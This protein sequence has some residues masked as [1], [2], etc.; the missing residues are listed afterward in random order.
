MKIREALIIAVK[1]IKKNNSILDAIILLS[2]TLMKTKKYIY[3]NLNKNLT[4]QQT[5]IF[6]S[7]IKKRSQHIPLCYLTGIQE[8][9]SMPLHISKHTFIPRPETELL[10]EIALKTLKKKSISYRLRNRKR[11]NSLGISIRKSTMEYNS[12]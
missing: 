10:I 2:Y 4:T 3:L 9:W 12:M 11:S 7:L 6:F 8:F 5:Q 1:R